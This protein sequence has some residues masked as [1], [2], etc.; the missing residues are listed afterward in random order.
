MPIR[1][2]L[3][4]DLLKGAIAG[5][6]ATWV[7]DVLTS[8]LYDREDPEARRREDAARGGNPAYGA[9]AEKVAAA[10]GVSLTETELAA[11]GSGIHWLL[12]I[13]AGAAY[14]VLR[15]RVKRF[16][17]AHGLGFGSAFW[18]LIDETLN[19]LLGLTPGPAAFPWQAHGRGLAGH[20]VIWSSG[21]W[22]TPPWIYSITWRRGLKPTE[23]RFVRL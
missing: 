12:G 7:M 19:P 14:G 11:Y 4:L 22:R 23:L 2:S 9:A 8:A 5:A 15:G 20:L 18:L 6:A 3:A 10:A 1:N 17:F 21:Q 16:G 13:G